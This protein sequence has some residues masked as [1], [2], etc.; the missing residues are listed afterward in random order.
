M[1]GLRIGL[2]EVYFLDG[3]VAEEVRV[4]VRDVAARLTAAGATVIDVMIPYAHEAHIANNVTSV[5]EGFA[6]HRNNLVNRWSDF[7]ASTR[8]LLGRGALFSGADYDQ[9]QRVRTMF[10]REIAKV[11]DQVDVILT[12]TTGGGAPIAAE[13]SMGSLFPRP[14]SPGSGICWGYRPSRC[15]AAST[16]PACRCRPRLS[17]SR[18]TRRPSSRPPTRTSG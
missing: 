10:R 17:A 2:P 13:M 7:G 8:D 16:R 14:V 3:D 9:A 1:T 11:F 4:A 6:Y 18:S 15:P 12:P 5:G